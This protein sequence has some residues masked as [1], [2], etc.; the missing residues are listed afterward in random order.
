MGERAL[1]VAAAL[2]AIVDRARVGQAAAFEVREEPAPGVALVGAPDLV[3]QVTPQDAAAY[4][5][6]P[7]LPG[8]GAPPRRWRSPATGRH[9]STTRW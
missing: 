7:G 1:R 3:V 6:P 9:C 4:E 5:T 8:R 2:N